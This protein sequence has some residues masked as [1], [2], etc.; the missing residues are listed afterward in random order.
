MT[1]EE[2]KELLARLHEEEA[3]TMILEPQSV[4]NRGVIGYDAGENKL[5]Y[6]YEL[7]AEALTDS[8]L[9]EEGVASCYEE[10]QTCAIDWLEY[11]TLRSAPYYP[12]YPIIKTPYCEEEE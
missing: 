3:G 2:V 10:A 7:L 9:E 6:S 8:F 11:N 4:F 5:I 1:E 12:D